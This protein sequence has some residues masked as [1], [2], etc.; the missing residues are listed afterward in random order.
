MVF[1]NDKDLRHAESIRVKSQNYTGIAV[2]VKF[3]TPTALDNLLHAIELDHEK[4]K[5][6]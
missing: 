5:P 6:K 3:V 2:R 4:D 1:S